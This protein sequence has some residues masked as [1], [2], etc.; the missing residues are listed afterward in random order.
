M[1]EN[2]AIFIL[3]VFFFFLCFPPQKIFIVVILYFF[4]SG[5]VLSLERRL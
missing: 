3:Q 1:G 4:I 5:P 2:V